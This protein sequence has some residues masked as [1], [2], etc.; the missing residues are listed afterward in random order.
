MSSVARP[1]LAESTLSAAAGLVR[2][3]A[4]VLVIWIASFGWSLALFLVVRDQFL[5]F[6]LAR[7]DLGNMVQ[8]VWSTAHGRPLEVTNG[9]TGEQLV[10]LGNHVDPILVLL[11][12]LWLIAPTPQLLIAVQIVAVA[13][14]AFPLFWLGRR[15]LGSRRRSWHALRWRTSPIR[16][17][18]GQ[19]LTRS[20][21]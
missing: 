3:R 21:L 7:Y 17:P 14:G 4:A 10:R 5:H 11:A 12:P 13:A 1:V 20:I 15:R 18:H 19:P 8:A 16:G 9:P 6:R 2:A